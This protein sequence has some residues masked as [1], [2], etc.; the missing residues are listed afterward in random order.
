MRV[1]AGSRLIEQRR[2]SEQTA[3][4]RAEDAMNIKKSLI[5]GDALRAAA[6]FCSGTEATAR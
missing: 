3:S 6:P 2:R 1:Q 5:D 4:E